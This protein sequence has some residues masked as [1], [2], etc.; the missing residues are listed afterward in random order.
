LF[1]CKKEAAQQG[2]T[3]IGESQENA[4]VTQRAVCSPAC[5]FYITSTTDANVT[6]CGD[7]TFSSGTCNICSVTDGSLSLSLVA[8]VQSVVCVDTDGSVCISISSTS[9]PIQVTVQFGSSSS[10]TVTIPSGGTACFNT[11]PTCS[12]TNLGC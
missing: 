7:L 5:D 10:Q 3:T 11:N 4:S 2:S 9:A 8:N 1:S 12:V 6:L